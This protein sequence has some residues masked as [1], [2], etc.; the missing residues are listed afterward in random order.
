MELKNKI[1]Q[2]VEWLENP[3]NEVFQAAQELDEIENALNLELTSNALNTVS[4]NFLKTA[5]LLKQSLENLPET[6]EAPEEIELDDFA[7]VAEMFDSS[8]NEELQKHASVIDELLLTIAV[9]KGE[10]DRV[11]EAQEEKIN[12]LKKMYGGVAEAL[13]KLNKIPEVEK[14]IEASKALDPI[15]KRPL[16]A[17]LSTR[18][19]PN[20][21]GVQVLRLDDGT[22][23]S[24]LDGKVY[25]YQEGFELLNGNK[26][27]GGSVQEQTKMIERQYHSAFETREQKQAK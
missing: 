4:L 27:P 20:H 3:D 7:K 21:A 2:L 16:E 11:K 15:V 25:N 1:A 5:D 23:Q 9:P 26:V 22:Y 24:D 8:G 13:K 17:P 6:E 18:Y 12:S 14:A 19:D 10:L